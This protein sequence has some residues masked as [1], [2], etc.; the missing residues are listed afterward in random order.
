MCRLIDHILLYEPDHAPGW[1]PRAGICGDLDGGNYW[2]EWQLYLD[3][4]WYFNGNLLLSATNDA[5]SGKGQPVGRQY[6][7]ILQALGPGTFNLNSYHHGYAETC[8]QY[9]PPY[10][11]GVSGYVYGAAFPVARPTI[12]GLNGVWW[13]G[14]GSDPANGY[15]NAID[16]TA[17]PNGA[18]ETPYWWVP[19]NPQKVSLTCSVCGVQALYSAAASSSCAYDVTVKVSVGGFESDPFNVVVNAPA[20]LSKD[21]V[22]PHLDNGAGYASWVGYYTLDICNAQM[23]TLANNEE[24]GTFTNNGTGWVPPSSQGYSGFINLAPGD[25]RHWSDVISADCAS[26][27]P[28]TQNPQGGTTLVMYATQV[29]RFG[30]S[31]VSSGVPVR[32]GTA[33]WYRDHGEVQ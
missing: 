8:N 23:T 20:S 3:S 30:S 19:N 16:L 33:N 2:Y 14:G 10:R 22:T 32:S 11:N 7:S 13:L 17:H 29:W 31:T 25:P 4:W 26:C 1:E 18:P 21:A 27:T 12:T 5:G 24:F 28:S 6:T 9:A 15:Y